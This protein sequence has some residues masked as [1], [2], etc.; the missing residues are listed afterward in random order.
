[1]L[2]CYLRYLF[3]SFHFPLG[4]HF[5]STTSPF[6]VHHVTSTMSHHFNVNDPPCQPFHTS[7]QPFHTSI[8]TISTFSPSIA[9]V[10]HFNVR[11]FTLG[12]A[13]ERTHWLLTVKQATDLLCAVE[14]ERNARRLSF[15]MLYR[16]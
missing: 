14:N 13:F 16:S 3:P 9:M 12:I 6:Y 2:C 11:H 5:T 7:C 1:M 4:L 8:S 15:R 10:R